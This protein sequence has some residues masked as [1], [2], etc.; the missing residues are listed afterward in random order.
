[1]RITIGDYLI[2][3]LKELGIKHILGVPG[4]FNLQFL[5]QIRAH[6]D[7][8]FVGVTNELNGA[9]AA[10]GYSRS[11]GISALCVTYGVG[12]LSAL[13]G[14]AGSKAEHIPVIV[15]SGAPPLYAMK[16]SY[17]VHHTLAD[18]DFSNIAEVYREFTSCQV[19]ITPENASYEIDRAIL[20]ALRT[21]KPV[22]LQIPSNITYLTIE[23]DMEK[24]S[25]VHPKGDPERLK[26]ALEMAK[27]LYKKAKKPVVL[28]DMDVDR[29]GLTEVLEEWIEKTRVPYATMSTGKAVLSEQ[30]PLYLGA[31]KGDDSDEGVQEWVEKSDFLLTVS[32]RFIEWNS[33]QYSVN[34]PKDKMVMLARNYVVIGDQDLEGIYGK[35]FMEAVKNNLSEKKKELSHRRQEKDVVKIEKN[36]KL[37]HIDFWHQIGDFLKEGDMIF[38]ETGTSNHALMNMRLPAGS[39]Y[40]GSQIWGAIGFTLPAYFGSM[41]ADPKRRQILFIGDGSF[42]VTAQEYSSILWRK[43]NSV[44]FV[45]NNHGYTIERYIMGMKAPYNDIAPWKYARLHEV[46]AKDSQTLSFEV[47]T[48]GELEE[49]LK[50]VDNTT[51]GILIEVHMNS[52]D[53]PE[54]L[55]KFGPTVAEFNFGDRGPDQDVKE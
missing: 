36:K 38:G 43:Q 15:I 51:Q 33:G 39:T 26:T 4:D 40:V 2:T 25:P 18:G 24:L 41:L 55:K 27:E 10:D 22:N 20:T 1:M 17:K 52:E 14:V 28:V 30:N 44:I 45:I 47:K 35:E 23:T 46:M 12:D 6:E 13:N 5:E 49:A 21:R 37:N 31:Y 3:R 32:P 34:L 9:Y 7:I 50:S 54:A 16:Q 53:A 19:S 29:L 42:Q 11:H 8:E 48:Q